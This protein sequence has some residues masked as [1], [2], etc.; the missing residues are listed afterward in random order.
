MNIIAFNGSPRRRGN[1]SR[2]L[3]E[4]LRGAQDAGARTEEIIA[5]QLNLKYCKGCLR[6]NRL[7][8]CSTQDDDWPALSQKISA[9]DVVVFASPVYF[10]H[11]TAS[12]KKVLD[13]FRSFIHV[14]ITESGLKH[15]P[16]QQW[17]KQFVLLLSLGSSVDDDA[18]PII[19]LFNFLVSVLGPNNR[20][21]TIV[22][23]RLAV[24]NQVLMTRDQLR[25]LYPKLQLPLA[26][27]DVDYERNKML[28]QRCYH[29]GRELGLAGVLD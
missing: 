29:L 6:C 23:A 16:W 14:Q 1:T 25:S 27:A 20:L 19:D 5:E 12:L 22:G 15:T 28:V 3:H 11:L 9:A 10:H 24:V 8:R 2:L 17:Q 26:L 7:Q 18:R 4:L 13:R 21:T